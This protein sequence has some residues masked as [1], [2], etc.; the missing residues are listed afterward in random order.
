[1]YDKWLIPQSRRVVTLKRPMSQDTPGTSRRLPD[2]VDLA[3][4]GGGPAGASLAAL[5]AERGWKVALLEKAR[6]PRFHIGESLLPKNLELFDLLGVGERVAGLGVL[7]KGAEFVTEEEGA[8]FFRIGFDRALDPCA[9]HAWQVR[10]SE[11]DALLFERA[12]EAGALACQ[13]ARVR[14]VNF[15]VADMPLLSVETDDGMQTLTAGFV[16]DASG[17]DGLLAR[18]FDLRR[19]N[20]HHAT[21][22]V[23]GHFTGIP[24]NAGDRA[25]DISIFWFDHGWIWMIPLPGGVTSVGAVCNP[26]Y[27]RSRRG[28]PAAFLQQTLSRNATAAARMR[29]AQSAGPV[30]ATGNYSYRSRAI[31]GRRWLLL[32][33]AYA[34]VDP[35]FSSGVLLGMNSARDALPVIDAE[36]AGRPSRRLR[37]RYRRR[38][39]RGLRTFS[40]FIYRFPSPVMRY[41]FTNPQNLLQVEQAVISLLAGDVYDNRRVRWRLHFFRLIYFIATVIMWKPAWRA[42]RQRRF[43]ARSRF[44]NA[45]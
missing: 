29:A 30:T 15:D 38:V 13:S 33:D 19:T 37:R 28:D 9:D 39:E 5:V 2:A 44:E 11:F 7:K 23:Y 12:R 20:R 25:G 24:R 21:A 43:N 14:D 41:L 3:V 42:R 6:H 34:F 18:K 32:G 17:R 10:R 40:W 31:G 1:M 22:A 4:I 16:A 8:E 27:M 26:G 35:V 45:G 36:L